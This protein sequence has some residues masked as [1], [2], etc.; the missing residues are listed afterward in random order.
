MYLS[1]YQT[2]REVKTLWQMGPLW[3]WMRSVFSYWVAKSRL[4]AIEC[5]FIVPFFAVRLTFDGGMLCWFVQ[6]KSRLPQ[7][8]SWSPSVAFFKYIS[9][10]LTICHSTHSHTHTHTRTHTHTCPHASD[11]E[12][13]F[14][15]SIKWCCPVLGHNLKFSTLVVGLVCYSINRGQCAAGKKVF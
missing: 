5:I 14:W 4:S 1:L 10:S 7:K 15:K 12:T 13:V 9:S 8:F 11:L 2:E 6:R 3:V